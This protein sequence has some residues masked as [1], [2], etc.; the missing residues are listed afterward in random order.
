MT[1][2]RRAVLSSSKKPD[3]PI[4]VEV[5]GLI[6]AARK[7]VAAAVNASLTTLY[8][9]IGTR[10]RRAILRES[11]PDTERRFCTHCLQN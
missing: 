7:T 2:K 4:V 8:W 9:Q 10:I 1:S 11:G 6:V 5:R 3:T